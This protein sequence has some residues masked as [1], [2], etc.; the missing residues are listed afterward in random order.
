MHQQ[1]DLLCDQGLDEVLLL[2]MVLLQNARRTEN[3]DVINPAF[4]HDFLD[5]PTEFLSAASDQH[6]IDNDG[7]AKFTHSVTGGALDVQSVGARTTIDSLKIGTFSTTTSEGAVLV[8][9]PHKLQVIPGEKEII[10][11]VTELNEDTNK[12]ASKSQK[13]R[14][15]DNMHDGK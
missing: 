15:E 8:S 1:N 12:V 6:N 2:S 4:T 11:D 14:L 7:F 9:S 3:R 10:V 13:H 5:L